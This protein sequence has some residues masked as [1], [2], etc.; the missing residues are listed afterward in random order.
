MPAL[1]R[2]MAALL[3]A[4]L[5]LLLTAPHAS[6]EERPWFRSQTLVIPRVDT[7]EQL[8][9]YQDVVMKIDEQGRGNIVSIQALGQRNLHRLPV[10]DVSIVKSAGHPVAVHLRMNGVDPFCGAISPARIQQRRTGTHFEID[11]TAD[12]APREPYR[13]CAH[14]L[15]PFKLTAALDVYGLPA[16]TYTYSVHGFAAG[17]FTL[18][19]DNRFDDDCAPDQAGRCSR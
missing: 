8:G 1:K 6:A 3:A 9:S 14:L 4:L 19:R 13:G 18:E 16:G 7:P 2:A 11:V 5:A 12:R 10:G 15:L 17:S